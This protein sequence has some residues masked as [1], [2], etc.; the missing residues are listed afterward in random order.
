MTLC[1]DNR[2]WVGSWQY[3]IKC[4]ICSALEGSGSTRHQSTALII[5]TWDQ[6]ICNRCQSEYCPSCIA[7][8]LDYSLF[9]F[10]G[11]PHRTASLLPV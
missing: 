9:A 3:R 6:Q 2:G 4:G 1:P 5:G 7:G 11:P 10:R 8:P